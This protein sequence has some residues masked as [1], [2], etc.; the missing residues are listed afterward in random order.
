MLIFSSRKTAP[1]GAQPRVCLGQRLS[2]EIQA[3]H[4][5]EPCQ[6]KARGKVVGTW[7]PT[8]SKPEPIDFAHRVRQDCPTKLP[9]SGAALLKAGR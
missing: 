6:V 7:L 2:V 4:R 8:P 1:T 5:S 9:F 3:S